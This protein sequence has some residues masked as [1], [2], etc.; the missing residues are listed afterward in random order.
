[1]KRFRP[2]RLAALGLFVLGTS[3]FAWADVILDS[4]GTLYTIPIPGSTDPSGDYATGI[5]SSGQIIG[6][7]SGSPNAFLYSNGTVSPIDFGGYTSVSGINDSG[8]ILAGAN[9]QTFLLQADGSYTTIAL[10]GDPFGINDSGQI[11]GN[12]EGPT[13]QEQGFLDSG[14][15]ITTIDVPDSTQ[16]DVT[17]I[18]NIGQI[19]GYYVDAA[20]GVEH[21]F[22]YSGGVFTTLTDGPLTYPRGINDQGQVAGFVCTG[23]GPGDCSGFIYSEGSFTALSRRRRDQ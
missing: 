8:E 12:T 20:T 5:N 6:Y 23:I 15:V 1:M 11:V 2:E 13:G 21:G 18:N 22:L 3:G 19:V 16:T 17:G 10:P 14:G 9:G 4:N 7:F